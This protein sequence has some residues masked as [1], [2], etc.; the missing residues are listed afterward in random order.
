MD[1]AARIIAD[2]RANYSDRLLMSKDTIFVL[3][4]LKQYDEAEFLI[5]KTGGSRFSEPYFFEELARIYWLRG[6]HLK[7]IQICKD[8]RRKFPG[9]FSGYMLAAGWLAELGKLKEADDLMAAAVRAAPNDNLGFLRM[10]ARLAMQRQ[11]WKA[12]AQRWKLVSEVDG[13]IGLAQCYVEMGRF[14]DAELA[15]EPALVSR[16]R[17]EAYKQMARIAER[18][19]DWPEAARRWENVRILFPLEQM[20]YTQSIKALSKCE[21]FEKAAIVREQAQARFPAQF[22]QK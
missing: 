19:E 17:R 8:M 4:K 7:A 16:E 21:Q 14:D 11:D 5:K 2:A 9:E 1:G 12:A 6:D 20:A 15:L 22:P 3:I 10:R 13:M 18:K